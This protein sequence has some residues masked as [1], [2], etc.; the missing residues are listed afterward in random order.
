VIATK[1][2]LKSSFPAIIAGAQANAARSVQR[3]CDRIESL[4]K[5]HSRVDTGHMREEW[6]SQMTGELEGIVF[7]L[8][9]YTIYNEYGTMMMPAQPMLTPAVEEAKDDFVKEIAAGYEVGG[10]L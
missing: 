8:V 2:E 5:G 10:A 1:A 6:Q 7:N 3:T 9:V 4:A